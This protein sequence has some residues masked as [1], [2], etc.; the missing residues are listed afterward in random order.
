MAQ[1]LVIHYGQSTPHYTSVG[2]GLRP[3]FAAD[4]LQ[5][6]LPHSGF[7]IRISTAWWQRSDPKDR[8]RA[9]YPDLPTP[10]T[11][12]DLRAGRDPAL[13]AIRAWQPD[14]EAGQDPP[15]LRWGRESQQR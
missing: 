7:T 3:S 12:A 10:F 14:P 4:A 1:S 6:E 2:N 9:L 11:F 15:N 5:H 8:R 13:E